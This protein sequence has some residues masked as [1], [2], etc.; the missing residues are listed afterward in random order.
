[1][2]LHSN[3]LQ[4]QLEQIF[5]TTSRT[6]GQADNTLYLFVADYGIISNYLGA[7]LFIMKVTPKVNNK[8][9]TV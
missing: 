2:D 9:L 3:A 5:A 8:R 7:P 4:H 1:M 6:L